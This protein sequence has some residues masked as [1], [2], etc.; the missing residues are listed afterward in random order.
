EGE[1]SSFE[2]CSRGAVGL[3][4]RFGENAS[5][6]GWRIGG[7]GVLRLRMPCVSRSACCAQDDI[8]LGTAGRMPALLMLTLLS[9][10]A[11]PV[12]GVFHYDAGF[13]QFGAQ[14]IRGFEI[15]CFAGSFHLGQ[16]LI[17]LFVA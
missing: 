10:P 5:Q 2:H 4:T 6:L 11:C 8:S 15:S 7:V 13:S 12:F 9:S 14:G 16:L 17:D 1:H 3:E